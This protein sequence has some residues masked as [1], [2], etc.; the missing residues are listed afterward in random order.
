MYSGYLES[1]YRKH[2]DT[3]DLDYDN[4]Y[5]S[6]LSDS[7]EFVASYVNTFNKLGINAECII[8]NDASLQKKW[9]RQAGIKQVSGQ[10]TI[11]EQIK[12]ISPDVLWIDDFHR[13][14]RG[15]LSR[16][17]SEVPSIRLIIG[18]HC[19][20]YDSGVLEKMRLTSFLFTCTPGMKTEFENSGYKCY[21]LYHAF[22]TDLLSRLENISS[23]PENRFIFS[24]SLLQGRGSHN[25]RIQ[26]IEKLLNENV[27]LT[28]YLNFEPWY[29][30]KAKQSVY[31]ANRIITALNL[32]I[33]KKLFPVF[34]YIN[35]PVIDYPSY[36]T[37]NNRKPV[38]GIE[39]YRLFASAGIVLNI[40]GEATAMYCGNMRMF[41]ATGAGAC[42][43][44][45]NMINIREVFEPGMEIIVYENPDDCIEKVI[46]LLENESARKSIADAGQRR[47]LK[48]HTVEKR[49]SQMIEIIE[50][51][52]KK[53]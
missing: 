30:I 5:N 42:L 41:E 2:P 12:S 49:C 6:L 13:V 24:G 17:R 34:E 7:T 4:H 35:S 16:V 18:F 27:G 37:A 1:F 50:H 52:L 40:H 53:R 10:D 26:L 9:A 38:F 46:W 31:L 19:S 15:L 45:E 21:H 33:L 48:D 36:L 22:D 44:T 28:T 47:T 14:E 20:P 23:D 29:K 11:L 32:N 3:K 8:A 25:V 43:L 51:E 39:M